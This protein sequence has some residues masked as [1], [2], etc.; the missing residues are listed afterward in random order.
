[1]YVEHIAKKGWQ[2]FPRTPHHRHTSWG[3]RG[4]AV[5]HPPAMEIVIF[6]VKTL[7]K[8]FLDL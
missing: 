5:P 2:H 1:M 7:M 4:A 8:K 3:V 6:G